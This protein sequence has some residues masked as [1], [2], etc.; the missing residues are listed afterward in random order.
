MVNVD[1]I[2]LLLALSCV[3]LQV[4]IEIEDFDIKQIDKYL[5]I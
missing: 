2:V 3:V 4:L 1:D 5:S